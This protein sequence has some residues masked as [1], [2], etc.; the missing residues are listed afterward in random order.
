MNSKLIGKIIHFHRKKSGLSQERLGK[1]AGVGKT[2]VFDIEHGK[3]NVGINL[4]LK[5]LAVLN[6]KIIFESPLMEL[7]EEEVNEKGHSLV[8]T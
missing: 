2:T 7:F 3:P 4:L 8:S 1:L 6:I 5:L